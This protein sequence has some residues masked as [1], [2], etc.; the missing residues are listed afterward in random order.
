MSERVQQE[1]ELACDADEAWAQVVDAGWLGDDGDL[2]PE[3]GAEGHV[4]DDGELR[5]L[6]V[7]QVVPGE[8]LVFRWASFADEPSRVEIDVVRTLVGS[9]VTV[10]ETPLRATAMA[11]SLAG[12]R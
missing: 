10:T 2:R 1:I 6:L 4:V 9:R 8:R 3:P 5:V 11:G 12:A 7:E